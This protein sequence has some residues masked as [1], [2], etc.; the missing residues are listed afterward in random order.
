MAL[1]LVCSGTVSFRGIGRVFIVFNLCFELN[2]RTPAHTTVLTWMKKL[3]V[4][5]FREKC[6]FEQGKWILIVDESVQF[7]NKKLLVVLAVREDM[8]QQDRALVYKDLVPVLIRGS[9]SWKSDEIK[10]ELLTRIDMKQIAYAV[11]DNGNNLK[12]CYQ[13]MGLKHIEDIG[14][15]F[16]WFMKEVF[17]G[18]PDFE[19][20]TRKLSSLR[21][22]L[23]LSKFAGIIPPNQRIISRF[24]NLTPLFEWGARMLELLD[25]KRLTQEEK[26]K[27]IFVQEYKDFILQT[28]RL[29]SALN[30][31]QETVKTKQL[32][33]KTVRECRK[34]LD[35]IDD[36]QGKKVVNLVKE[37]FRATLKK[38][39]GKKRILCCSDIIESCFGKY[40][41][42]VK[43][44]KSTGITDLC[45]TI[46]CLTA[47]PDA[48]Q[49]KAVMETTKTKQVK[50]WRNE[51]LGESLFAKRRKLFRKKG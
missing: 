1:L 47:N 29:L 9:V 45:L 2:L 41:E 42:V 13:L 43:N 36:M 18:Y 46:S 24:M 4:S 26:Q 50:Q 37:Y 11:S 48:E 31:I 19:K 6:F 22:K 35:T 28:R 15:K 39:P 27:V 5:N 44:N 16:S 20:Y 7:G 8:V 33:R 3:G 30:L 21:G 17:A 34:I 23:S 10:N 12:G 51:N 32:S 14:H 49:L 40:K 25:K 38:M